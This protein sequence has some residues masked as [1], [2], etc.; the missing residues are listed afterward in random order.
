MIEQMTIYHQ[1]QSHYEMDDDMIDEPLETDDIDELCN[2]MNNTFIPNER[3]QHADI[4]RLSMLS[5]DKKYLSETIQKI[6]LFYNTSD[7]SLILLTKAVLNDLKQAS[8][9]LTPYE[10]CKFILSKCSIL[11]TK[12]NCYIIFYPIRDN[13]GYNVDTHSLL[14]NIGEVLY[15]LRMNNYKPFMINVFDEIVY[16]QIY[17]YVMSAI[18]NIAYTKTIA[19]IN[20]SIRIKNICVQYG[21]ILWCYFL[22]KTKQEYEKI[23]GI[24][25]FENK[26]LEVNTIYDMYLR[27]HLTPNDIVENIYKWFV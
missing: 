24:L 3:Y 17:A 6:D 11:Q 21:F 20:H 15:N 16:N 27:I 10:T 25:E 19:F 9:H 23:N 7:K 18:K 5:I 2:A 13:N 8:L 12:D 1:D 14:Y 22:M 4:N 26:V